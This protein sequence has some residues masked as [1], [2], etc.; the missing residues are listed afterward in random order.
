MKLLN[1]K[2]LRK[3]QAAYRD[4]VGRVRES[5]PPHDSQ[6]SAKHR[7][8]WCDDCKEINMWTYWQG[9][10]NLDAKILLV[11]QDWGCPWD[12]SG[13][14][15][16]QQI[17]LANK[18]QNYQYCENN[19]SITDNNLIRLFQEIGYADIRKPC[20]DLFFT[21]FILGYRDA[22]TSGGYQQSWAEHD[23]GFFQE[24]TNIIEPKVILCL[25][26]STFE[27][28]LSALSTPLDTHIRTYNSFI[29]S[30]DNP[31]SISLENGSIA[32]VFALAHCGVMGMLNRNGKKTI[33]LENQLGDWR[34]ILPYLEGQMSM[35]AEIEKG[36]PYICGAA[37]FL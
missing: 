12:A 30:S 27:G 35:T 36:L 2:R 33:D 25:G 1:D 3:K 29:E 8:S 31:I 37:L 5:Y 32:H 18:G 22:G 34:K 14:A 9:R 26:R 13:Q 28:V 20:P 11:G 7:L 6:S 21:N 17:R 15:T 23:K 24:L 19:P 16:M 10:G 4:L